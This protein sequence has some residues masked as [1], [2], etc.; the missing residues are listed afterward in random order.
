M[1]GSGAD[2]GGWSGKLRATYR[3]GGGGRMVEAAAAAGELS[4]DEFLC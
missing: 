3:C 1:R 4:Q 2:G